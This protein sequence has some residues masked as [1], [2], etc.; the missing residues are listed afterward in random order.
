MLLFISEKVRFLLILV[1]EGELWVF[2]C[3]WD[4]MLWI[5]WRRVF[6]IDFMVFVL[7]YEFVCYSG[8]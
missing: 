4:E 7:G 5:E 1:L 2:L 3:G 8:F 6:G